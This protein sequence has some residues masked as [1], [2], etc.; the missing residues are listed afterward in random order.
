MYLRK[1]K[2][3]FFEIGAYYAITSTPITN[4][5]YKDSII[6][7]FEGNL[8]DTASERDLIERSRLATSQTL[9][10]GHSKKKWP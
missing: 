9:A 4:G 5:L 1:V 7:N 8:R 3:V 10:M 2:L 6:K